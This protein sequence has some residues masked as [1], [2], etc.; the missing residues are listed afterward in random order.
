MTLSFCL[1]C[2]AAK[3]KSDHPDIEPTSETGGEVPIS[4]NFLAIPSEGLD[5]FKQKNAQILK[6]IKENRSGPHDVLVIISEDEELPPTGQMTPASQGEDGLGLTWLGNLYRMVWRNTEQVDGVPTAPRAD[7]PTDPPGGGPTRSSET[8]VGGVPTAPRAET[9]TDPPGGGPNR[10]SETNAPLDEAS[11]PS[12]WDG[13]AR[14]WSEGSVNTVVRATQSGAS[15]GNVVG[16]AVDNYAGQYY[17]NMPLGQ[18]GGNVIGGLVAGGTTTAAVVV[19][20]VGTIVMAGFGKVGYWAGKRYLW[21]SWKLNPEGKWVQS[22]DPADGIP[23]FRAADY[24]G[25]DLGGQT[26]KVVH[27]LDTAKSTWRQILFGGERP[28]PTPI[29]QTRNADNTEAASNIGIRQD[30]GLSIS[31]FMMKA[32]PREGTLQPVTFGANETALWRSVEFSSNGQ[33]LGTMQ[34]APIGT[35]IRNLSRSEDDKVQAIFRGANGDELMQ[36]K[37]KT[38]GE[39][40]YVSIEGKNSDGEWE[41]FAQIKHG[42]TKA[43]VYDEPVTRKRSTSDEIRVGGTI[44]RDEATGKYY[45]ELDGDRIEIGEDVTTTPLISPSESGFFTDYTKDLKTVLPNL[46]PRAAILADRVALRWWAEAIK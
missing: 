21:D 27:N 13:Y 1:F 36:F 2:K 37:L 45:N 40:K 23:P 15:A 25:F 28:A 19:S 9:P 44:V 43:A 41:E 31:A 10:S 34:G 33:V 16:K 46:D 30:D 7:T 38:E 8:N 4:G 24:D 20:T 22:A 42:E 6:E 14:Y 11:H 35:K 5:L 3:K 12:R 39:K 26:R 32:D 29:G 17:Y 18:Y